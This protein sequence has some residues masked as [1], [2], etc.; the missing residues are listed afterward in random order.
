M[1]VVGG[2]GSL[3][4]GPG[5]ANLAGMRRAALIVA[6]ALNCRTWLRECSVLKNP[7]DVFRFD[8]ETESESESD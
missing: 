2:M 3:H 7:Y 5:A 4:I 8:E 1:F 6:N